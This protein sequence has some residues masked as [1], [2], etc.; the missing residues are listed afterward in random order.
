VLVRAESGRRGKRR[1]Y[2]IAYTV[3]DGKG[4]ACSGTADRSGTTSA[5]VAIPVEKGD[6]RGRRRQHSELGLHHWSIGPVV[7]WRSLSTP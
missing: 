7:E 1:V 3:S 6:D 5:L 2:R 4:R